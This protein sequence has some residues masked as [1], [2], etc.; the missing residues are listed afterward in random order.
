MKETFETSKQSG[1]HETSSE[2]LEDIQ[3]I[4]SKSGDMTL[5]Y[6]SVLMHSL[7]DPMKEARTWAKTVQLKNENA[8]IVLG[9]GMGYHIH[10]LLETVPQALK[11]FVFEP[12]LQ[13]WEIFKAHPSNKEL[14]GNERVTFFQNPDMDEIGKT[15]KNF[16]IYESASDRVMIV[17]HPG[18]LRAN[19]EAFKTIRKELIEI[20]RWLRVQ[21]NTTLFFSGKWTANLFENIWQ[22]YNSAGINTLNNVFRNRPAIVVSAGPSL[23]KNLHHLHKA[24]GKAIIVCVGTALRVLLKEGIVPDLVVTID[25]GEPNARHFEGVDYRDIPLVFYPIVHPDILKGSQTEN[26]VSMGTTGIDWWLNQYIEDKGV[27][28]T[29]GSVANT[30][31]DLAIQMG[32]NPIVLVGQDLAYSDGHSHAKGTT[33]SENPEAN[34]KKDLF[35]VEDVFGGQVL[36]DKVLNI[37]REW[38]EAHIKKHPERLYIDATE[39]GAKIHG[40]EIMRLIDFL[41][42]YAS[43]SFG[44][45]EVLDSKRKRQKKP[46]QNELVEVMQRAKEDLR[47]IRKEARRGERLANSLQNEYSKNYPDLR[48]VNQQIRQ[49]DKIDQMIK[50]KQDSQLLLTLILQPAFLQ[51]TRG[52][53]ADPQDNET[54]LEKGRRVAR[55]SH[56]LYESFQVVCDEMI[57]IIDQAIESC[58]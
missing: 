33:Q 4:I 36:T 13:V 48:R 54:D 7:Y 5:K 56:H 26:F 8:L 23:N 29:G 24:K 27:L 55:L 18:S 16:L 12:S 14:L 9:V 42:K 44:I 30:A 19:F 40:T 17:E 31:F 6:N 15:L 34:I 45:Q 43:E 53:D 21:E 1:H 52:P 51:I 41:E 32:C 38:F 20:M 37:Y 46:D 49:M 25:G 11:L 50:E 3:T 57:R 47:H 39:G 10:A 58:P 35:Y 22:T 28:A 2:T